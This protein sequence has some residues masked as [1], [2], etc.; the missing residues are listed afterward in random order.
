MAFYL[1]RY[2]WAAVAIP[3][4]HARLSISLI[5]TLHFVLY[6]T[7]FIP[8]DFERGNC[9]ERQFNIGK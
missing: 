1:V 8:R 7:I 2:V 4:A 9:I 6:D 5:V 3:G